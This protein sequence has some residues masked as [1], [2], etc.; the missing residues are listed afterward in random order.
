MQNREVLPQ[1]QFSFS[2]RSA[3]V[4]RCFLLAS[5]TE[6]GSHDVHHLDRCIAFHGRGPVHG[7]TAIFRGRMSSLHPGATLEPDRRSMRFMGL[8]ANWPGIVLMVVGAVMLC[9]AP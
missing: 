8:T 2:E 3:S 7:G 1:G 5:R 4:S 9:G 6:G